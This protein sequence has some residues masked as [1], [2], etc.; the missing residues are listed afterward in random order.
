MQV[1]AIGTLALCYDNHKVFMGAAC[2]SGLPSTHACC[3][4]GPCH[5]PSG[6]SMPCSQRNYVQRP[7]R[8]MPA[9]DWTEGWS[10]HRELC[11]LQVLSR[12]AGV[13]PPSMCS[14]WGTWATCSERLTF[15]LDALH[16]SE[17]QRLGFISLG[18][19]G[20]DTKTAGICTLSILASKV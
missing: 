12:C 6:C 8:R 10:R 20:E 16:Q 19:Q 11:I 5:P 15:L 3:M 2:A 9:A 17:L 18:R 1:M 13:R 14:F 7:Y 4:H